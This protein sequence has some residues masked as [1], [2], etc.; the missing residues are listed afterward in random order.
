MFDID[1]I[2]NSQINRTWAVNRS[3]AD[4]NGGIRQK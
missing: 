2:Y 3:A 4:T 1:G